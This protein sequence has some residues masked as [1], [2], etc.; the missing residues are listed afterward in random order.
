MSHSSSTARIKTKTKATCWACRYDPPLKNSWCAKC[1]QGFA[2]RPTSMPTPYINTASSDTEPSISAAKVQESWP[3]VTEG[4][5]TPEELLSL[6]QKEF[7]CP[8]TQVTECLAQ[9]KNK[10]VVLFDGSI[11]GIRDAASLSQSPPPRI[12]VT[13]AEGSFFAT[14]DFGTFT[15]FHDN[16]WKGVKARVLLREREKRKGKVTKERCKKSCLCDEVK[17]LR[18]KKREQK[19]RLERRAE[20]KST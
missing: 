10:N 11:S 5:V 16:K 6:L 14:M 19:L 8:G 15:T 7:A 3:M 9:S 1:N 4:K 18:E 2:M 13:A 20:R 17:R 12:T